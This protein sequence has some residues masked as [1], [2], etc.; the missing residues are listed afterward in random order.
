MEE[1]NSFFCYALAHDRTYLFRGRTIRMDCDKEIL[2][3]LS[4]VGTDGL[5]VRKISRHVYNACNSFFNPIS[6]E[7]VNTYVTG[8]LAR[9]SRN[10]NSIIEKTDTRG[11]YRL[12]LDSKETQ[13]LMLEFSDKEEDDEQLELPEEDQ[14]LSL[15]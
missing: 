3:V 15:F 9:N 4:E 14:S 5:V 2:R 10:P 12:N 11:V 6:F 7:E 13:Q 8:F 1:C